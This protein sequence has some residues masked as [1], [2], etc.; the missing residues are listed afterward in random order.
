MDY[1]SM[2]VEEINEAM[3]SLQEAVLKDITEATAAGDTAKAGAYAQDLQ[4]KLAPMMAALTA[5]IG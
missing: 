5:K 4:T 3:N 1:N 2:S